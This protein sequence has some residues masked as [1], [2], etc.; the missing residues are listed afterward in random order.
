MQKRSYAFIKTFLS[1]TCFGE[2]MK[3]IVGLGNPGKK[4]EGTRHN[5]GF[6][7]IDRMAA[8]LDAAVTKKECQAF[9]GTVPYRG[10]KILLA[11]PQTFMNKSGDA[12]WA[13]LSYYEDQLD[14]FLIIHDDLDLQ[15]GSMRFKQKGSSGGH[16]GL[17]SII[18]HLNS[19]DFDR[20]KIGIGRQENVI[21]HVL[22]PFSKEEGKHLDEVLNKACDAALFWTKEGIINAMNR[23]N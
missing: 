1:A 2:P 11:K 3:L 21:N 19:T 18:Q 15:V 14:D 7:V 8:Q 20:L 4:Y 17:K 16:N 12:V 6:H 9:T 23:Y 22:T 5:V 13:L 10:D